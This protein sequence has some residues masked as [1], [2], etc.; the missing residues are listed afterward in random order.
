MSDSTAT[1]LPPPRTE[2]ELLEEMAE[3]MRVG[4]DRVHA[5]VKLVSHDLGVVKDRVGLLEDWRRSSEQRVSTNSDRVRQESTHNLEQDSAIAVLK[6][7][8]AETKEDVAETKRLMQEN[9]DAT[10]EI[11]KAVTGVLTNPQVQSFVRLL[12]LALLS[13]LAS[14]GWLHQ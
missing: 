8:V 14:K 5:D 11:K 9:T 4:F 3:T 7:D 10:L 13:W 1:K 2:R 12:S 6:V